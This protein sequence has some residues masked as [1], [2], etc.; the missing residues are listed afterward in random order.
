MATYHDLRDL[1]GLSLSTIS[2][3]FNGGNVLEANRV[4]IADAAA[5][6]N[7]QPNEFGRSLRT[8]RSRTVG[9][10]LPSLASSFHM[11][12]VARIESE[13]R[14]HGVSLMV[15]TNG[16]EDPERSSDDAVGF[17]AQRMVDGLIVAPTPPDLESLRRLRGKPI[18]MFDRPAAGIDAD[19]VIVDN[20]GAGAAAA[21]LLLDHGHQDIG[22]L[23]GDPE[24]WTMPLRDKGFLDELARRDQSVRPECRFATELNVP[25]ATAA[26]RKLLAQRQRPTAVFATN[27][28][29]TLGALI[30]LNE[31][32]LR[33]PEDISLIGFDI[34]ELAPVI[35]PRITTIVQ[36]TSRMAAEAARLML[37]RLALGDAEQPAPVTVILDCEMLPGGSVARP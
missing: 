22:L 29:L 7:F 15:R 34:E 27:Y 37:E 4:A 35:R 13:L 30:A 6:L 19:V 24:V 8:Q 14:G 36:P 12:I 17:L 26:M 20:E 2:K 32:G 1:T 3:Y 28:Q 11:Q 33:I 31:S 18:V 23:G 5:K 16:Y 25:A 21:R 9:V 10:A